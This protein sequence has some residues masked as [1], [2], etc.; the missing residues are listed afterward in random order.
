MSAM[1]IMIATTISLTLSFWAF[2]S[3]RVYENRQSEDL[4]I[5]FQE[6]RAAFDEKI[7]R[8]EYFYKWKVGELGRWEKQIR[9]TTLTQKGNE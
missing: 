9:R 4:R 5:V 1:S 7:E 2:Q 8:H 6:K 3:G